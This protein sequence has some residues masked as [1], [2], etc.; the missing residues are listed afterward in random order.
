MLIISSYKGRNEARKQDVQLRT[1]DTNTQKTGI[2]FEFMLP[3][4]Y[5]YPV[6]KEQKLII[7]IAFSQ[8]KHSSALIGA[9]H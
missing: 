7:N 9:N 3:N 1:Y 6:S 5:Y 2:M 8:L 4:K